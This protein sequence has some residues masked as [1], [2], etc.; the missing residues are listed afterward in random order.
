MLAHSEL[1]DSGAGYSV[2]RYETATQSC[3]RKNCS[4]VH[5]TICCS[6]CPHAAMMRAAGKPD[7]KILSRQRHRPAVDRPSVG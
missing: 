2:I 7:G 3:I 1:P 6:G 5:D 4:H